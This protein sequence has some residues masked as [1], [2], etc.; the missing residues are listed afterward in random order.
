MRVDRLVLRGRLAGQVRVAAAHQHQPA[1]LALPLEH[2]PGGE[3]VL[4]AEHVQG[5]R[6]REQLGRGRG[7]GG[8]TGR[9]HLLARGQVDDGRD[10]VLAEVGVGQQRLQQA[11]DLGRRERRPPARR[12]SRGRRPA[13]PRGRPARRPRAAVRRP[14]GSSGPARAAYSCRT[15]GRRGRTGTTPH[16]PPAGRARGRRATSETTSDASRSLCARLGARCCPG[17]WNRRRVDRGGS[18]DGFRRARGDPQGEPQQVRGRPRVGADP[19][20]PD[21]VHLDAVPRR[22]RVH[23]EHPRSRRR[24]AG[25]PRAADR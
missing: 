12:R 6:R 25:R 9:E 22:L 13:A 8:A 1:L 20:G 4:R 7:A 19:A 14:A 2:H 10:H 11:R 3:P 23:R 18:R 15:S 5:G 21:A 24:P 17:R 16:H